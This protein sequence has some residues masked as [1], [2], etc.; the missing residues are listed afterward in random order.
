MSWLALVT[1][2]VKLAA[3]I[4]SVLEQKQLLDAGA[5]ARIA[6]SLVAFNRRIGL[7]LQIVREH[8]SV[9][10]NLDELRRTSGM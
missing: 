9:D 5:K 7:G 6:D 8:R 4:A 1:G 10:D 3:S 2:L